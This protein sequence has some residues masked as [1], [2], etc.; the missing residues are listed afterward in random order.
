M[1]ASQC[2]RLRRAAASEYLRAKYSI[3][4]APSTLAKLAV[5][6]GGPRFQK[7]GR[8]P[9]YPVA[10]LDAWALS[11]LSPLKASTSDTGSRVEPGSARVAKTP[12]ALSSAKV[13]GDV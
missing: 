5:V 2:Q 9:L 13:D 8:V 12:V 11:I 6:G 1:D 10:E 3:E 7:A 4:R